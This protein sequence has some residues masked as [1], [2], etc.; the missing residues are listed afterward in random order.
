MT[1]IFFRFLTWTMSRTRSWRFLHREVTRVTQV[2]VKTFRRFH[3]IRRRQPPTGSS[4]HRSTPTWHRPTRTRADT[5]R[6]TTVGSFSIL[7]R[8][9]L[10]REIIIPETGDESSRKNRGRGLRC[11]RPTSKKVLYKKYFLRLFVE[12]ILNLINDF[13]YLGRTHVFWP[14]KVL[15]KSVSNKSYF[16]KTKT[17]TIS[18]ISRTPCKSRN[19]LSWNS[20]SPAEHANVFFEFNLEKNCFEESPKTDTTSLRKK[21]GCLWEIYNPKVLCKIL[22]WKPKD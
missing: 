5:I 8:R 10:R 3:L 2:L 13:C 15:S 12:K 4:T 9:C 18:L 6:A 22:W 11:Y 21:L 16:S 7:R 17:K 20:K 14:T 19:V 1:F